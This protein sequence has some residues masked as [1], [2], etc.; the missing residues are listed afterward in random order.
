MFY[1]SSLNF[2]LYNG[3][4]EEF[5]HMKNFNFKIEIFKLLIIAGEKVNTMMPNNKKNKLSLKLLQL[6]NFN[7]K[8]WGNEYEYG[9]QW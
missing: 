9:G 4:E 2:T 8:G 1:Y 7:W 3:R 5:A 6:F